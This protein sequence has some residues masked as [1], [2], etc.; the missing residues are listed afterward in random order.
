M[1]AAVDGLALQ[2][3]LDPDFDLD[4]AFAVLTRMQDAV[5]SP[6]RSKPI[7]RK[8]CRGS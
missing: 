1:L 3:L 4:Q 5:L 6:R 8:G 7:T 2:H